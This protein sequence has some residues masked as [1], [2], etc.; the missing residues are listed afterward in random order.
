MPTTRMKAGPVFG[1]GSR[2]TPAPSQRACQTVR[3]SGDQPMAGGT[4]DSSAEGGRD[5]TTAAGDTL[6]VRFGA[7]SRVA[8]AGIGFGGVGFSTGF[9]AT[10]SAA[11]DA[12]PEERDLL[13]AF[14]K[15]RLSTAG[16]GSGTLDEALRSVAVTVSPQA[17][18][19]RLR[20]E[21]IRLEA[22]VDRGEKKTTNAQFVSKA[23]PDVVAKERAK[24]DAYR[25]ELAR[26]RSE[27][28]A[29]GV[30]G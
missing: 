29:L 27:L 4:V 11:L 22:E 20:R 14:A 5:A 17:R 15:L 9:D 1:G 21:A 30:V 19:E 10:G 7:G 6:A 23:A 25:D 24:L 2:R 26:V 16:S 8:L 12:Y 28:H 3:A 13:G 18:A